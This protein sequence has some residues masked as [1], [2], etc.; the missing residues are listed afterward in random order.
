MYK[1]DVKEHR[2]LCANIS[3]LLLRHDW[4]DQIRR[5]REQLPGQP[6]GGSPLPLAEILT[7]S[8]GSEIVETLTSIYQLAREGNLRSSM[9]EAF[10]AL[11]YAPTY[12]PLHVYMGEL[13]LKQ[14]QLNLAINKFISV[15]RVY[16]VRG[17]AHRSLDLYRRVVD[18]SPMDPEPREKLID[19]LVNMG[20]YDEALEEYIDFAEMY[21]SLADLEMARETYSQAL[22]LT[23]KAESASDWQANILNRIADI[24]MQSLD[25]REALK[26]YEKVRNIKPDDDRARRNIIDLNFRLF[27]E[28][29]AIA[30]MDNYIS[31]L[32]NK[33]QQGK[34]LEFMEEVVEDNPDKAAVHRRMAALYRR[35][36]RTSEAVAQLDAAGEALMEAGDRQGAIKIVEEILNL[37]PSNRG[38][39]QQLLKQ[40]KES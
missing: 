9:E 8:S 15:A 14:D 18:L 24:D 22:R 1:W 39:Y 30:E 20:R 7:Q 25:W 28:V 33:D 3:N 38:E 37:N 36:G 17:E 26:M 5:A 11:E 4:Q 19:Q 10:F 16:S 23:R 6:N 31:Y 29:P 21:Y 34:A 32:L 12:L 27:Q 13:L 2:Q 40:L 35:L